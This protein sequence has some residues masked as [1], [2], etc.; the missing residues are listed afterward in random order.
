M[1]DHRG[2]RSI[3]IAGAGPAGLAAA[4]LLHRDGHRVSVFER[5]AV[6][7]P[8]GSGLMLQ[9]TG[10]AVLA[11][12]GLAERVL[13]RG[14]R[15]DRMFGR[16]LPSRRVVLDLHYRALNPDA[17]GLAVHR[18]T[19]FDPLFEAVQKQS[20]AIETGRTVASVETSSGSGHR[21]I[22]DDGKEAGPFDL[23]IDALGMRSPLASLYDGGTARRDLAYGAL[24]ATLPWHPGRFDAHALEQRYRQ[25]SVMIGV[26][27]IGRRA[28]AGPEE[29]AFFWS[30]K[31]AEYDAWRHAGLRAWKDRARELWPETEV[32]LDQIGDPEQMTLARYAHHT[33]MRPIAGG[34]VAI[35]DSAHAASPQ[36]GQGANMALLDACAL[37][38]ALREHADLATALKTYAALRRWHIR[39]YQALSAMFTP[40]YQSDS[41]VLPVLRDWI[42]APATRLPIIRGYVAAMVAG[43]I[44]DPRRT[45]KLDAHDDARAAQVIADTVRP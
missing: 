30:L 8:L 45:L 25:A 14:R 4:L 39:F 1:T 7:R 36:L 24:W 9:P 28:E 13:S 23:V 2:K 35:G 26:L 44:L 29:A 10:L 19:L 12:L 18:A 42:V 41:S 38:L 40:F 15:I 22:F 6:P 3:A 21:I 27:P 5:F 32:L 43:T 20:I 33:V 16:V 11:D 17:F 31:P 37:A 34:V